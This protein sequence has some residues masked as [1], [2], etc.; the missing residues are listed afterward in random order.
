MTI[1]T[2]LLRIQYVLVSYGA[3]AD[4]VV[5][6]LGLCL[7]QGAAKAGRCCTENYLKRLKLGF[8]QERISTVR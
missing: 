1:F 8:S 6:Q 7:V 2:D 4:H 5:R 3:A